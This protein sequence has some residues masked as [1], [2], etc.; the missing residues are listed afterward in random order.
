MKGK[1]V[2]SF[3]AAVLGLAMVATSAHALSV[4]P[5]GDWS[6]NQ[7]STLTTAEVI[8]LTG[9]TGLVEVYKQDQGGSESGSFASSYSTTFANTP[10][11]P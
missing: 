7:N 4:Q 3:A 1:M 9:I 11:D 8:A 10:T 5:P 2:S 6:S